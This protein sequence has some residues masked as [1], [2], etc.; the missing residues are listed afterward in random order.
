M[1]Q[2]PLAQCRLCGGTAGRMV[3][4]AHALCTALA[5]AGMPTPH[6]GD[7]CPTCRGSGVI[8]QGGVMLSCELGPAAIAESIAAQFPSCRTCGGSGIAARAR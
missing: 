7:R 1:T 2:V 5:G 6:L 8:G 4:G 3:D